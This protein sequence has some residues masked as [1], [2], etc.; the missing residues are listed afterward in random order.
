VISPIKFETLN[1]K[2]PNIVNHRKSKK[3]KV[4]VKVKVKDAHPESQ[5]TPKYLANMENF[6]TLAPPRRRRVLLAGPSDLRVQV[7][8]RGIV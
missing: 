1:Q 6:P 5:V 8:E 7:S 4:K 3:L 2:V